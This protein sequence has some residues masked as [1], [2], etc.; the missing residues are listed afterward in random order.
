MKLKSELTSKDQ[1]KEGGY[2]VPCENPDCQNAY[3]YMQDLSFNA[4]Q[5]D[6]PDGVIIDLSFCSLDCLLAV[7][8]KFV[9]LSADVNGLNCLN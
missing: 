2:Y 3:H 8:D 7:K 6:R 4:L 9:E 5:Q 1:L